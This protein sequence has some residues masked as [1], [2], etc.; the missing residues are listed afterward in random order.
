MA[1][2]PTASFN[3]ASCAF[4]WQVFDNVEQRVLGGCANVIHPFFGHA[5]GHQFEFAQVVEQLDS[6]FRGGRG[7]TG[8]SLGLKI[9]TSST[10]SRTSTNCI[11]PV[12]MVAFDLA[13]FRPFVGMV[14]G[15][16]HRPA[17]C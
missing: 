5:K 7:T 13:Q 16:R 8:A 10:R 14:V 2:Q 1:F 4:L 6:W 11:A 3:R 17:G 9:S 15:D 12:K